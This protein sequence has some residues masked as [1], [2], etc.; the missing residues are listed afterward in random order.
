MKNTEKFIEK[1]NALLI[2][3]YEIEKIYAELIASL[4]DPELKTFFKTKIL[5]HCTFGRELK[6]E[7]IKLGGEP[8]LFG[9]LSHDFYKFWMNFRNF[10]LLYDEKDIL[11]EVYNLQSLIGKKYNDLL[12]E[13]SLPLSTCKLLAKH[14]DV[15]QSGMDAIER[16]ESEVA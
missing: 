1:L 13:I 2:V 12:R 6:L 14:R 11:H 4:K 10:V 3:N 15:I 16:Q 7:I 5:E 9:G 8:K